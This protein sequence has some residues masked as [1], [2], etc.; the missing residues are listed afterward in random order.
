LNSDGGNSKQ[1]KGRDEQRGTITDDLDVIDGKR[2]QLERRI[3]QRH[4]YQ[5]DQVKKETGDW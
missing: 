5:K 1:A 4:G 3:L 2:N